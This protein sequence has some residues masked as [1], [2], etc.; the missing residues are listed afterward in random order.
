MRQPYYE[1]DGITIYHGDCR[2]VLPSLQADVLVTDPPYGIAYATNR[3]VRGVGASWIGQQI[4]NDAS[5]ALRDGVL[6]AWGER[7][8]LVFG[9]W[10]VPPPPHTR[11]VLIW[12][13]GPASGMGDLSLPWKCSH[14]EI[15]VLGRGFAGHRDEGVL[16][17][18]NIV[19]WESLGRNHPN[20]KPESLLRA[21]LGKCPSS[22][23]V[24]DP[25]MGGGST[26]RAAKDLNRRAIGIEIEERYCEVAAKR[27]AQGVLPL[28]VPA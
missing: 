16:R 3:V 19:T 4:Q 7:P 13:K 8:A 9:S 27:L 2:E 20:A 26:L 24:L 22:W 25:F 28:E 23:T 10:K 21:L 5:T 18:F 12:D 14:E 1:Q 15:Y 6:S 17:G 11:T